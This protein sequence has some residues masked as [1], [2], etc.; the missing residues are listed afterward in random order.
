MCFNQHVLV[1]A[2][3]AIFFFV[4]LLI[5]NKEVFLDASI[6]VSFSG[7]V[8]LKC[9]FTSTLMMSFNSSSGN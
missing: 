3:D 1:V 8:V 5:F 7:I 2:R 9:S 4:F 6:S